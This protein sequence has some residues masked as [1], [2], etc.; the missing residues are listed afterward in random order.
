MNL[1]EKL[2]YYINNFNFDDY[3]KSIQTELT[4]KKYQSFVD[5]FWQAPNANLTNLKSKHDI[6]NSISFSDIVRQH[7]SNQYI[8]LI[9]EYWSQDLD[10]NSLIK[11]YGVPLQKITQLVFPIPY[12]SVNFVCPKC[13]DS[14]EFIIENNIKCSRYS[15]TCSKCDSHINKLILAEEAQQIKQLLDKKANDFEMYIDNIRSNLPEI[16]CPKCQSEL[17][18]NS[19]FETL[20]YLIRCSK[21]NARY[22]NYDD[23]LIDYE[24]WQQRAAM[25]IKIK[26]REDEI[27]KELLVNKKSDDIKLK[28]EDLIKGEDS[29]CTIEY[30][31]NKEK[32]LDINDFFID[33]FKKIKSCSRLAKTLLISICELINGS[34]DDLSSWTYS[35]SGELATKTRL[36]KPEEPIVPLLQSITKI[37][38]I[39]K[40]LRELIK[41]NLIYCDEE[42]NVLHVHPSLINNLNSIK[43]LLKPKNIS[44]ELS[45]LIFSKQ[46]FTCY[47]CG[48]NGRPLKI[49]YLNCNK[50]NDQLS[51]MVGIC[52]L[53]Y[54]DVTEDDVLIDAMISG[55]EEYY[56]ESSISWKF[57]TTNYHDFKNNNEA[58]GFNLNLLDIYSEIDIIKA[59]AATIDKFIRENNKGN[60]FA[61]AEAILRNSEDGVVIN[62]RIMKNFKVDEWL[63]KLD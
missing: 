31:A 8:N 10:I 27:I 55:T 3:I 60:F 1:N 38:P 41:Q 56:N 4:E 36:L 9:K 19:N 49:A 59:Y 58:Y 29:I 52:D 53:C 20:I 5:E 11:K 48:E 33:L 43:N 51:N 44:N 35:N 34:S 7:P 24:T 25:M 6:S 15:V 37:L 54:Y 57:L 12:H 46:K 50:D 14:N 2:L 62:K 63:S 40:T 16:K 22:D 21:C 17:I 47:H 18:L 42:E 61:Y 28:M 32:S 45:W 39:R 23:L 30:F 26:A 13:L